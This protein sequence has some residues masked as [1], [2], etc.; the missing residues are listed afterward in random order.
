MPDIQPQIPPIPGLAESIAG[1]GAVAGGIAFVALVLTAVFAAL[2]DRW[3]LGVVTV[4][5]GSVA[6]VVTVFCCVAVG[7]WRPAIAVVA[8]LVL[9]IV[10]VVAVRW[11]RRRVSWR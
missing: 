4:T 11:Q 2:G 10:I 3:R 1:F 6:A 9:A 5:I 8:G 7:D